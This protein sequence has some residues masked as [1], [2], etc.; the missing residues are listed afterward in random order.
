[1]TIYFEEGDAVKGDLLVAEAR[2]ISKPKVVPKSGRHKA[3]QVVLQENAFCV[4]RKKLRF[5]K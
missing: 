3:I 2:K 5:V 4:V 1:M